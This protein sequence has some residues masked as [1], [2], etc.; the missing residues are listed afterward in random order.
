MALNLVHRHVLD[1]HISGF[2]TGK[3]PNHLSVAR[4]PVIFSVLALQGRD[5]DVGAALSSVAGFSVRCSGPGEWLIVSDTIGPEAA[6]GALAAIDGATFA[7]QSDG[8]VLM[9]LYGPSAR[10]ILAKCVAVDLHR[11]VFAKGYSASMLCCQVAS[12]VMR[13]MDDQ[14]EIILPRSYAGF[15]FETMM[16]MGREYALTA[17]FASP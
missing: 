4:R 17:G 10:K 7:D 13:T 3:N 11:D 6:A 5:G 14:F 1:D 12:N 2:E 16:E 9:A 15:V 8:K